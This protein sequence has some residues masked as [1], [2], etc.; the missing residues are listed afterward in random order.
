[1]RNICH[2]FFVG[3]L[4]LFWFIN[5]S[6]LCFSHLL[7]LLRQFQNN[8]PQVRK[9]EERERRRRWRQRVGLN[10]SQC[11]E[12]RDRHDV[13]PMRVP[14]ANSS[15]ALFLSLSLSFGQLV[16]VCYR[17]VARPSALGPLGPSRAASRHTRWRFTIK[18]QKQ[19]QTQCVLSLSERERESQ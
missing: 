6:V 3:F 19:K 2:L 1:M 10:G 14:I 13:E 8:I 7:L 17:F 5:L 9:R 15:R 16:G 18:A 12:S 4:G 11:T